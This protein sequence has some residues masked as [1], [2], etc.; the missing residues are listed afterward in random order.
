MLLVIIEVA[1][2]HAN[3]SGVYS[4]LEVTVLRRSG[5]YARPAQPA[6]RHSAKDWMKEFSR[7]CVSA[8]QAMD[9]MIDGLTL[10]K[11]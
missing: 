11:P 1:G 6:H 3:N 5:S 7:G 4:V 8:G 10:G 9:W 2:K